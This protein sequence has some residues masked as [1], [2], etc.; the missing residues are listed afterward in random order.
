[1]VYCGCSLFR[2]VRSK[3]TLFAIE[4]SARLVNRERTG[5]EMFL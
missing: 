5:Q 2:K 3:G 4:V 1:M